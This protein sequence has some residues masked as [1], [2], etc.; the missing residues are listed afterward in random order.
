[1]TQIRHFVLVRQTYVHKN[2][3]QKE[4]CEHLE[5]KDKTLI[6]DLDPHTIYSTYFKEV[7][8]INAKYPRCKRC[9]LNY[10]ALDDGNYVLDINGLIIINLFTVKKYW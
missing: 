1:M 9:V 6:A 7:E 5:T 8:A 2:K 10:R 4:V 3:L